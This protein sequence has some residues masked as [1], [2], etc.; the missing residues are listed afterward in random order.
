MLEAERAMRDEVVA[1]PDL[2]HVAVD[3]VDEVRQEFGGD[4]WKSVGDARAA[5][6]AAF[7]KGA[8]S[9]FN[10]IWADSTRDERLQLY[11]LASRGVVDSRRTAVL[12]SLVNRGLVKL[13]PDIRVVRLCSEAF[14]G[15]IR[16]DVD[17]GELNAWRKEDDGGTWQFIWPPLAVGTVLGLVFLAMA[18][19]EM[20]GPM[21][22][23]LLGLAPA[24]LPALRGGQGGGLPQS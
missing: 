22:T 3:V 14:G 15:F 13:N 2:L 12:S 16:H 4:N 17:H 20:R 8:A 6:V 24:A 23:A 19:P 7:R 18:N 5:A 21:L 11:A 1:N 10:Q 9:Y